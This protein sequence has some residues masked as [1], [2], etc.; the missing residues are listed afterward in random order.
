MSSSAS[1][2]VFNHTSSDRMRTK[3]ATEEGSLEHRKAIAI[4]THEELSQPSVQNKIQKLTIYSPTEVQGLTKTG[5]KP[6][7]HA[8]WPRF[9]SQKCF[10]KYLTQTFMVITQMNNGDY[11]LRTHARGLGGGND[12]SKPRQAKNSA[13]VNPNPS[14]QPDL[15]HAPRSLQP[16]EMYEMF[17]SACSLEDKEKMKHLIDSGYP[18]NNDLSSSYW[19]GKTYIYTRR[20][21][22]LI[23]VVEKGLPD[24][25]E[26]MLKKGANPD[27]TSNFPEAPLLGP[28]AFLD[29][30]SLERLVKK[31]GAETTKK[32]MLLLVAAG[33]KKEIGNLVKYIIWYQPEWVD[34]FTLVLN[35]GYV[36]T[37]DDFVHAIEY[38]RKDFIL[39]MIAQGIDP[40][41]PRVFDKCAQAVPDI[42]QL[43]PTQ[44]KPEFLN[45]VKN[46]ASIKIIRLLQGDFYS[47]IETA[48]K[49]EELENVMTNILCSFNGILRKSFYQTVTEADAAP[50]R[51]AL[52]EHTAKKL[53][54]LISSS[55][56]FNTATSTLRIT[57]LEEELK[58]SVSEWN[59]QQYVV[60][61]TKEQAYYESLR[62]A[63]L[64]EK[65]RKRIAEEESMAEW[66]AKEQEVARKKEAEAV[67][68]KL[69]EIK[70]KIY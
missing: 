49:L 20:G 69:D 21:Y 16:T 65:E 17:K 24:M 38:R 46:S 19:N 28:N 60:D 1:S 15:S 48:G 62:Q 64:A 45:M 57:E 26:Y 43:L 70:N 6:T 9:D 10:V 11:Q 35:K 4:M 29:I 44:E 67:L 2:I 54:E 40:K 31:H 23:M 36:C 41:H 58:T 66:R 50:R 3:L 22:P 61:V 39:L 12:L 13:P 52:I 14:P 30:F 68:K 7:I 63:D 53:N 27:V 42:L 8:N 34:I 51:Q 18:L 47:K 5:E 33:A 56:Y 32:I 25:V 37:S 59:R 55:F